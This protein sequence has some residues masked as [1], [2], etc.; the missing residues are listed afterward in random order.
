[1]RKA[2]ATNGGITGGKSASPLDDRGTVVLLCKKQAPNISIDIDVLTGQVSRPDA[3]RHDHFGA[4]P[5]PDLALHTYPRVHAAQPG[6][7][8]VILPSGVSEHR[9]RIAEAG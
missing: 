6:L 7:M 1:M 3:G 2:T 9:Q 5:H 4:V 8:H